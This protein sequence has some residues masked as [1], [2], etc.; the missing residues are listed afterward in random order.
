MRGD[1]PG[2]KFFKADGDLMLYRDDVV[3]ER[4]TC[5]Y[6]VALQFEGSSGT[7]HPASPEGE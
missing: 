1:A 2:L 7:H 3:A 6:I 4:T 5:F